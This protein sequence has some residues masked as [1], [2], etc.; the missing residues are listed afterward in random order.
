MPIPWPLL[1]WDNHITRRQPYGMTIEETKVTPILF[2][3]IKDYFSEDL[4]RVL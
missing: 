2:P 1:L 4:S 3:D